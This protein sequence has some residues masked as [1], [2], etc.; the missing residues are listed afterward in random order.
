[1][2]ETLQ[3]N[4]IIGAAVSA[5]WWAPLLNNLNSALTAI[6]TILG[7]IL[8]IVKIHQAVSTPKVDD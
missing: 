4:S 3:T 6:L 7:I 8:T 2:N 1:M 5:P